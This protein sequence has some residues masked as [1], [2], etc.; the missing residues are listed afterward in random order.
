MAVAQFRIDWEGGPSSPGLTIFNCRDNGTGDWEVAAAAMRTFFNGLVLKIPNEYTLRVNPLINLYSE[1]SGELQGEVTLQG[2]GIPAAVTGTGTGAH[3]SGVG[4]RIDWKTSAIRNGRRVT[5]R[6]YLV[7]T[8]GSYFD[9]DGSV[10]STFITELQTA[11]D[12][13]KN[14]LSAAGLELCVWSRPTVAAPVGLLS[15][16]VA[17]APS[18][19]AAVLRKRRD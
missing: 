12:N 6:T 9:Q 2:T 4:C 17:A 11:G 1:T 19:K 7:P 3:A 18:V 16:V 15:P 8:I 10:L 14:S 5:G 13:L